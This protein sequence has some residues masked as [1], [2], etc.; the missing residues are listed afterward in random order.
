MNII[1]PKLME[2]ADLR[3]GPCS[4]AMQNK[5]KEVNDNSKS[6]SETLG[7]HTLKLNT[8]AL[9]ARAHTYYRLN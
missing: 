5:I 8:A 4:E 9:A 2:L 6:K 3:G 7:K 1:F